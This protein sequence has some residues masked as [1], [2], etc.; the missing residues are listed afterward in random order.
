MFLLVLPH[1]VI[2]TYIFVVSQQ[3]IPRYR[4]GI[5]LKFGSLTV[6]LLRHR[7][8]T[9]RVAVYCEVTSLDT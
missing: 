7:Q 5:C 1:E 6:S 2:L 3:A 9:A 4:P 8:F